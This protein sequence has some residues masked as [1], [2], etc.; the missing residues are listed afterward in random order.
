MK[1]EQF[2]MRQIKIIVEKHP[3]GYVAYPLGVKGVVVGEGDTYEEALADVKSA[4]KFHIESFGDE[5]LE[6]D[7]PVLEAFVAEAGV[8]I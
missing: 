5:V 2:I 6:V 3:D 7:P 4:L 1:E 8:D